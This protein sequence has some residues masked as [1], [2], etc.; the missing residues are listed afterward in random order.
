MT[1]T[2]TPMLW[3]AVFTVAAVLTS[4]VFHC[5][6]PFPA[7]AAFAAIHLDSRDGVLLMLAT[8]VVS[9]GI[10]FC[11]AGY[12]WEAAT[13]LTG[14]AIGVAA[15]LAL[16]AAGVADTALRAGHVAVR[17]SVAYVVAFAAFKLA[18]AAASPAIGHTDAA[19]S[20]EVVLRQFGRNAAILAGLYA[21]YRVAIA[22]GA[23]ALPASRRAVAA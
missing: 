1:E 13:A 21:A 19:L 11:F 8:W 16:L 15:V 2:R 7:L 6:T 23:P 17:L 3:I 20:L 10:G 4:L 14:V 5:A 12:P 22:S 9:Q 18:I